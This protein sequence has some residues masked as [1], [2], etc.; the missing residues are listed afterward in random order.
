[1]RKIK[2]ISNT[3]IIVGILL[4]IVGLIMNSSSWLLPIVG[5][6]GIIIACIGYVYFWIFWRC[7]FCHKHLPF[8]G[9]LGIKNCPYCGNEIDN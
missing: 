6:G 2:I 5:V 9:M 7:S 1:M 3:F 8:N 4:L